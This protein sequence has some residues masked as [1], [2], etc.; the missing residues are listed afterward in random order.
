[1]RVFPHRIPVRTIFDSHAGSGVC[2]IAISRD[3]KCLVTISAGMVQV[4]LFPLL[5]FLLQD[6]SCGSVKIF[7]AKPLGDR[8]GFH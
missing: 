3:A 5:C 8:L 6:F 2:A 1:M 7:L 4:R